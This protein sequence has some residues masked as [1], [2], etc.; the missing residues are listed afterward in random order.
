MDTIFTVKNDDLARLGPQEAV[1]IFRELLWAEARRIG[2]AVDK[3]RV[4]SWI[5]VPDGGIDA[6]VEEN[7][8]SAQSDIIKPGRTGYQIKT[9]ESFKP[10]ERAQIKKELFGNKDPIRDNLGSSIRDCL[11]NDGTYILICFKQDPTEEQH[12]KAVDFLKGYFAECG[13]QNPKMEVWGQNNLIGFLSVFPSLSLKINGRGGLRFQT[14]Q[15]W[16]Q[17][18]EMRREFKTGQAQRDLMLSMQN[19][20]RK[21][22]EAIHIRV[23]GEPGI[24][25][26]RLVLETLRAEDLQPFVVY[27]NTASKFR[28]SDL[29]NEILRDDNRFNLIIVIDECDPDSRSYIWDKLKYRGSRIKLISIYNEYDATSGDIKYLETPLLEDEQISNIIQGYGIPKDQANRWVEFCSGSPMVAHVFG[30]NLKN[31]PE[32]LLKSPDTV[33]VWDRYVVR[34]DDPNS[35]QV[36]QRR[37]VLQHLSLFKRFGFGEPFVNEARAIAKIIEKVDPLLTWPRFQEV[38]Q[39]LKVCKILQG[40]NTLYITPKA[41]HIKLW[42]DWWNTYGEGFHFEEF[43]E[44]IPY[45]L[46]E[47]FCEMFKY[48]SESKVA[49]R[50]V[51]E[52]LGGKGPFKNSE[53]LKTKLG[54]QFFLGLAEADPKS[55]LEYLKNT[56][57]TWSKEELLKFT[58]GRREVIW[59]LEKIGMWEDL[60]ADATRLLLAL[61][62]AENE[63]WSSNA[64]GVFT[65]FFSLAPGKVAPTETPPHERFPILEEALKSPSKERRRL[66]LNACD[67]ALRT[68]DFLRTI[69][70]EYQGLR[71]EPQLWMPKTYGELFDAYRQVWKLLCEQLDDLLEDERQQAID[72]LLRNSR[73]LGEIQNLSDMVIDTIGELLEK[74]Y[75]DKKKVLAEIIQ[76]LHYDGKH[77]PPQIRQRWEQLK[78]NLTGHDF[79]SLMKRYVG[80]DLL[81]DKFDEEGNQ[82]DQTQARIEE[83]AQQAVGNSDLLQS[84]L[85]WL[86]TTE[87]Q[88]G[89]RFGYALGRI[90]KDFSLLSTLLE[91]QRNASE[92]ASVY[93]LGGYFRVLFEKEREEWEKQLDT[94][95]EDKKL[96]VWVPEL[97]WRSGMSDRAVLR[98]LDLAKKGIVG[99]EN[100][101]MFCVGGAIRDLSEVVFKEWIEFLLGGLDTFSISIA[102]DLYHFYYLNGESKY[103]LPE[104]LTLRLLTH[105]LLFQKPQTGRRDQMDYY[106]WAQIGKS[107]VQIYPERSL[108]LTDKMLEHFGEND[109][110]FEG[111]DGQTQTVLNEIT[112][113]YPQAVWEKITKYL[114]PPIDSRAFHIKEWLRGGNFFEEKEGAIVLIPQEV[115][116]KWVDENVENRAWYLASFV[117]K[118]LFREEGKTCLAVEV[119]VRY[120]QREDVRRNLTANFSTEGWWG[121][122]SL[123]YQ[124]KKQHL[125]DFKKNE[126]N[127]NVKRWIDEYVS[128]LDR[129]IEQAKIEEERDNF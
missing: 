129:Y 125:L 92:N 90:D 11:D 10:W 52:L 56:V 34:G 104:E 41:L 99:V 87:A 97:T 21:S 14:Y 16:S 80:M 12:S 46:H 9:G 49:S 122:E 102:L 35:Q 64:S 32:D 95:T 110:I 66:A 79:S 100:F 25:K 42:L 29:M 53:Y 128:L 109:T 85:D 6:S 126:D 59:A 74:S 13:Y 62:E 15:S 67:E 4:S 98:V 121:S 94:L 124:T 20:L 107:F 8:T 106:Y 89:Y 27:C 77:L 48:A 3:I 55:A 105:P 115:I 76:I 7:N 31:N 88:N 23:W 82:V 43:S 119:L 58:T 73:G 40:E 51:R 36:Q 2:I 108:E 69:G 60:F 18:A 61:G 91:A 39:N 54:A 28:D 47:W 117:P 5:N 112:K 71:K 93:F 81:E 45:S 1:D 101:R 63:S 113:V 50:I 86:V 96:N 30:Q 57:G 65:M 24:G 83:L 78:D 72:I 116:W 22:I 118:K 75:V 37:L 114:G 33:N 26:T 103:A 84:E 120:G 68:R 111:F 19:E 127:E 123:H 44:D 70:S 38:I 17:D